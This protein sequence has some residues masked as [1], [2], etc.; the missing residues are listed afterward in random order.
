MDCLNYI[1]VLVS[2]LWMG[3]LNYVYTLWMSVGMSG[4]TAGLSTTLWLF[5]I[6]I[7]GVLLIGFALSIGGTEL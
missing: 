3:C 7:I 5:T 2:I 4:D 1:L 6:A